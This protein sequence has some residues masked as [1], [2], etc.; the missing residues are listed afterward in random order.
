MSNAPKL[1]RIRAPN[2]YYRLKYTGQMAE[3]TY[4]HVQQ[5]RVVT[6]DTDECRECMATGDT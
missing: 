5:I 3:K 2:W 4:S 1:T 6:P